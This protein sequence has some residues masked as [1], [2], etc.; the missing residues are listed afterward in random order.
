MSECEEK[1][2]LSG[3]EKYRTKPFAKWPEFDQHDIDGLLEVVNSGI[4]SRAN[5]T[6]HLKFTYE[7]DSVI[8]RFEQKLIKYQQTN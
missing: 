4:W 3:G 2:A 8:G 6:S 7:S 5:Y 1:L